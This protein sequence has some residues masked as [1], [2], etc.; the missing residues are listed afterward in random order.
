MNVHG[1]HPTP[2][3]SDP[4]LDADPTKPRRRPRLGPGLLVTAAFIGPGTVTTASIAGADCG[5][6]RGWALVFAIAVVIK[7]DS[8]GPAF[9]GHQRVGAGGEHFLC[10]KFRTMHVDAERLLE[11]TGEAFDGAGLAAADVDAYWLGTAQSGMSGRPGPKRSGT[12][13]S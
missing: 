9:Y 5:F 1:H 13:S 6:A 3:P 10:W 4:A 7:L 2:R 8:P 11:A 12:R